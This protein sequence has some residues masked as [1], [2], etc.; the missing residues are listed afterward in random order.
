MWSCAPALIKADDSRAR[1]KVSNRKKKS[2]PKI[3]QGESIQGLF[4]IPFQCKV[5]ARSF[6]SSLAQMK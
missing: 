5:A 6:K 2:L 4:G 3:V 1:A